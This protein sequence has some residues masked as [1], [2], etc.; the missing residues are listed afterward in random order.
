MAPSSPDRARRGGAGPAHASPVESLLLSEGFDADVHPNE[1]MARHTAYRIG[2]PAR[3]LV[4]AHSLGALMQLVALCR[5]E[6]V[7]WAVVGRGTNLLVADEGYPGVVITLGRDFRHLRLDGASG[8]CVAGAGALLATVVQEAFRAGCTGLEFAVGTPGS[9]GGA[10]RMNAGTRKV[11]IGSRVASVTVLEPSGALVRRL[12]SEVEWGYRRSSFAPGEAI[13]EC[14]LALEPGDPFAIQRTMESALA[15]RKRTQPLGQP[16][17]G[18]VFRNPEGA[19]VGALVEQ[20]GL[21]GARVG[22][23]QISEVHGNFIVNTGGAT[24]RDVRALIDLVRAKV[25]KA[26]GIELATEVRLL[27]FE[28]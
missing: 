14:E 4:N 9:I 8:R 12:G 23:A 16:S 26:H 19:S 28:A 15:R 22:A 1:P 13:V 7:P 21:K 25:V 3:F 11:G 2:G 20:L 5:S 6:G 10:L 27:G 17:C 24:A 18:S